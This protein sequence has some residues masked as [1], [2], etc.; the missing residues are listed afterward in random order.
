MFE[1]LL[2]F[3]IF[4]I[5]CKVVFLAIFFLLLILVL[6]YFFQDKLLYIPSF[7]KMVPQFMNDNPF[8]YR[9]P[10]ERGLFFRNV[11]IQTKDK[12]NLRGWF[13]FKEKADF[14]SNIMSIGF[15]LFS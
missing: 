12:I 14:V 3:R 8:G 1:L 15:I 7:G 4:N 6:L 2:N 5:L 13:G 9:S 10:D 11:T